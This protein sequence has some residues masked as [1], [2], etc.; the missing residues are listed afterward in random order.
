LPQ[1]IDVLSSITFMQ[2]PRFLPLY[3]R[4][5]AGGAGYWAAAAPQ[6][7]DTRMDTLTGCPDEALLALAEISALGHW[8]AAETRNGSLSTRELIRRGDAIEQRLKQRAGPRQFLDVDQ[9]PLDPHVVAMLAA[10]PESSGMPSPSLTPE[11]TPVAEAARRQ[12]VEIYREAALLYLHTILSESLPAVPE[13]VAS[14]ANLATLI[15]DLP[16]S[17]LDRAIM[18][19]LFLLGCMTD[20]P[21]MQETIKGRFARLQNNDLGNSSYAITMLESIWTDRRARGGSVVVDW[22]EYLRQQQWIF[23]LL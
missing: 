7:A 14:V 20:Q 3:H 9:T 18:F 2:P 13:I 22:R 23:L 10:V 19:P 12:I 15:H 11:G 5:W 6:L 16:A 1:W 8:K 4:L 17:E 21:M